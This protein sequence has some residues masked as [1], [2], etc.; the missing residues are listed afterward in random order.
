MGIYGTS[1]ITQSNFKY[2]DRIDKYDNGKYY[3]KC[4]FDHY[5]KCYS[6]KY[7]YHSIMIAYRVE[8]KNNIMYP[9]AI[10]L[11]NGEWIG[12]VIESNIINHLPI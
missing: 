2:S 4:N 5:K 12:G 9:I 1:D 10:M 3:Y 6:N 11:C 7:H 8:N